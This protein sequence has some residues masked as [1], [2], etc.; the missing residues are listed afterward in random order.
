[1]SEVE[2]RDPWNPR[3]VM[4]TGASS[5]LGRATAAAV[6]AP[7][8]DAHRTL[9]LFEREIASAAVS[10]SGTLLG[11][12]I[13]EISP[14]NFPRLPIREDAHM[15]G[16]TDQANLDAAKHVL[17]DLAR[18]LAEEGRTPEILRLE[19]TPGS[20]LGGNWAP[21]LLGARIRPA[22]NEPYL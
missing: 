3:F 14:N 5:G 1:M 22:A 20:L 12:F 13:T 11:Y 21:C 15:L 7:V 19:R 9:P 10:V 8:A 2:R 4:V 17:A 18:V 6:I 16:Y